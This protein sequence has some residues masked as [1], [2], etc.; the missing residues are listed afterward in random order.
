MGCIL[1]TPSTTFVLGPGEGGNIRRAGN[2]LSK[3]TLPWMKFGGC[4]NL[5]EYMR[6]TRNVSLSPW[7]ISHQLLA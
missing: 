1:R 4:A 5:H 6:A 2:Y 3:A 7:A